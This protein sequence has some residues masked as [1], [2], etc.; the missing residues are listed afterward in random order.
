MLFHKLFNEKIEPQCTYCRRG[1][2]LSPET[3]L[4]RKK[5]VMPAGAA[6]AAFRYDPLKRVPPSHAELDLGRIR[7]EDLT[8]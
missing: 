6:C 3:V 4:C 7:D 1:K 2:A 8:L 5:G